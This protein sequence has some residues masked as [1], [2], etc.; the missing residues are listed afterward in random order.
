MIRQLP[1]GQKTL[2]AQKRKCVRYILAAAALLAIVLLVCRL[3]ILRPDIHSLSPLAAIAMILQASTADWVVTWGL[4]I[5]FALI[6]QRSRWHLA[7]CRTYSILTLLLAAL[8]IANI[9]AVQMLGGPVTVQWLAF[10]D[11]ANSSYMISTLLS[12]LKLSW[13]LGGL[14]VI[15]LYLGLIWVIAHLMGGRDVKISALFLIP[16]L[17]GALSSGDTTPVG[18]TRNP[19]LAM[20]TSVF[21]P[22]MR[23]PELLDA[24]GDPT[25]LRSAVSFTE[26]LPP[27]PRPDTSDGTVRN[28]IIYVME[29]TG[30]KYIS[31]YAPEHEVTPQ[32][33]ALADASLHVTDA[34]AHVPTSS[35]SL[36]SIL[37]AIVPELSPDSMTYHRPDLSFVGLPKVLAERG[38]KTGFFSSPDN[39]FQNNA[40]FAE[41]AGFQ[42]IQD[43]RDF[44]CVQGA[45]DDKGSTQK[46]LDT[47]N[48][49][50]LI[51]AVFDFV[52]QD[53][54]KPFAALLWTGM[55]HYPYY[56]GEDPKQYVEEPGQN[57]Y[58]NAVE[59]DDA[60]FGELVQGLR[61]RGLFDS[62]LIVVV[63]DHGEAFGEHQLFGHITE[64]FEEYLRIPMIFINPTL[65]NGE[66]AQRIVGLSAVAPTI[67]DLLD[68]P[69]PAGWQGQS[70]FATN[71]ANGLMFFTAWNGLQIGYREGA[72]KLVLNTNTDATRLTDLAADPQ[73]QTD[74]SST[75]P[76]LLAKASA[77]L[78]Y[79]VRLH[80]AQTQALLGNAPT[81]PLDE[82]PPR[83][84]INASGTK[85]LGAPMV[86]VRLDGVDLG[87][88]SVDGALPNADGAVE[89]ADAIAQAKDYVLP[90]EI[91]ACPKMLELIFPNDDWAG[92]GLTGDTNLFLGPVTV[93][94][95][96]YY[97]WQYRLLNEDVGNVADNIYYIWRAGTIQ[98]DLELSPDCI[99]GNLTSVKNDP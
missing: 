95:N 60:V 43:S 91:S 97:P 47:G 44:D 83:I 96:V 53:P 77:K 39:R 3:L 84:T 86:V 63:G 27:V 50:C 82:A 51:P 8:G 17:L 30:A 75:N 61:D 98:V 20:M 72:T 88:V 94:T 33:A 21:E 56:P 52:D 80:D 76:D 74:L 25:T 90:A 10:S 1:Q 29:S 22:E 57:K 28:V 42:T 68:I 31:G 24:N 46:Y 87:T 71:R 92:E 2:K 41:R 36:V 55:T 7:A 35:Y 32:I 70:L 59:E 15:G 93:G 58:I 19:V 40:G 48:D 38:Y 99:V 9:T 26:T 73:E 23:L 89:W 13:I 79:W 62:T 14:L 65:F 49:H 6:A 18:K 78:A 16:I 4:A 12:A 5:V 66:T 45:E 67:V 37:A 11:I 81:Q 69:A 54:N 85:F 64:V 34:Y